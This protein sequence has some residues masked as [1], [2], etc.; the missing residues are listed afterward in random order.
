M[1]DDLQYL[2]GIR[3][4][5]DFLGRIVIPSE[6]RR[7]FRLEDG[8]EVE[9]YFDTTGSIVIRPYHRQCNVCGRDKQNYPEVVL[10]ENAGHS[11]CRECLFEFREE[12]P[13]KGGRWSE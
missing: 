8:T 4:K 11:I 2:V 9:F 1:L 5:I 10:Y 6:L 13:R 7:R 12:T 3:R